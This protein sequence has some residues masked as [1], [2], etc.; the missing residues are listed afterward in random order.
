MAADPAFR[1]SVL[2]RLDS[3]EGISSRPM[4]GGYGVFAEG[5][6]FAL[7]SGAALFFKV[8]DSN[9]ALYEEA[10]SKQHAP[11]PYYLVP[12][13]VM[14]DQDKLEDWAKT[15]IAIARATPKK[16]RR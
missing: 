10:G 12:A 2:E 7:I 16:K 6:M 4:F 13:E 14:E 3:L 8:D 11:I 9:R 5:D 15:S 1:D